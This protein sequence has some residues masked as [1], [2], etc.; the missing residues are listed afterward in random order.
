MKASQFLGR[1]AVSVAAV[2]IVTAAVFGLKEIA[3]VRSL[4]VLY[5]FAVLPVAVFYGLAFA[6]GVSVLSMLAFN[7]F[8]LPPL[9]TLAFEVWGLPTATSRTT[10]T[11]T[12]RSSA[13]RSSPTRRARST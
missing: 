12:S 2:A 9:Y 1:A 10:C 7:Y 5:L 6:I 4:S 8:F 3:P 13:G 11:S